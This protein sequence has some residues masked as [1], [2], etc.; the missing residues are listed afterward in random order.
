M[1]CLNIHV[2]FAPERKVQMML[3]TNDL[4]TFMKSLKVNVSMNGI[5]KY[6][7]MK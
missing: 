6:S 7:E 3:D 5:L 4:E 2:L 1:F